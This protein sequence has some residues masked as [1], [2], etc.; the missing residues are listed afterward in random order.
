MKEYPAN[1][2]EPKRLTL[3]ELPP[4]E[5]PRERLL[6][7]GADSLTEAELLAII[8]RD[9][10]RRESALDLARR[11]LLKFGTLR[12]ILSK[13]PAELKM[14]GLG[15]AR[16]AQVLAALELARRLDKDTLRRGERFSNSRQVFDHFRG[17]LRGKNQECFVCLLLDVKNRIIREQEIS[18][19]GL[20]AAMVNPRDVLQAAVAESASAII[21]IHNH[22]SGDPE[23][24]ADDLNVTRRIREACTLTGIRFLDH[25]IVGEEGYTSLAD[26]GKI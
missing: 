18:A 9:G 13:R 3:K 2:D 15:D 12:N 5:R 16:I 19:G 7:K 8:I 20:S 23:P 17:K 14:P 4:D 21:V 10:T 24:S 25:V 26:L 1:A 6:H 22:P 11:L